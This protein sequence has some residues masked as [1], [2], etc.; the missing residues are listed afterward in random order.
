M[1]LGLLLGA[2]QLVRAWSLWMVAVAVVVL[3]AAALVD[4]SLRRAALVAAL[5]RGR[6]R[7]GRA[8]ALVRA[9]G[10]PATRIRSSTGRRRTSSCSPDGR[11]PSTSTLASTT[12]SLRPW[13]GRFDDRF[14]PVL[15]AETWGDYFGIWAWGPGRGDRTDAID[16]SLARQSA[17]GLLPTGLALAGVVALLGLA[18]TRPREDVGRLIAALPPVAALVSVLYLAVA[19]PTSD[20][21]TIKGTYALAAA[22]ALA[23]CFGF[24]LDT[25]ARRRVVGIALAVVLVASALAMLPFLV[26]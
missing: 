16:S 3:V 24:A 25:L 1:A 6:A 21:D 12:S 14:L 18:V 9:P 26:W 15:Y 20:G 8:C 7:R 22:P 10:D 11:S 17:L 5:V 13:Q 4:R 2:G 19:Y 23:L